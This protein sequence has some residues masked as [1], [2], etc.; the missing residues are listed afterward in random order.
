MAKILYDSA[1]RRDIYLLPVVVDDVPADSH[2]VKDRKKTP[3]EKSAVFFA[4]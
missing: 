3:H 1:M 4:C 2:G